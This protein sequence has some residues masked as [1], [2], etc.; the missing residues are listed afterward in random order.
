MRLL[1]IGLLKVFCY[2][3]VKSKI[4]ALYMQTVP[5][6][7]GPSACGIALAVFNGGLGCFG[8]IG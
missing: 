4:V 2:L 7:I 5:V 6:R 3:P 1:W 8:V